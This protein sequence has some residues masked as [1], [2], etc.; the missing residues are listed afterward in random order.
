M[1][2]AIAPLGPEDALRIQRQRSQR[3]QLGLARDLSA[4]EAADLAASPGEAW[5]ARG[6]DGRLVACLGLR[7]TFPGRQAVAWAIL[8]EGIGAAHL[9]VTRFARARIAASPLARIEALVRERVAAERRWARLVEAA[10]ALGHV[11][12]GVG[13][14]EAGRFNQRAAQTGAIEEQRAG[15]AAETRIRDS[16]RAAIG[17]QL[18]AQG[19]NGFEQGSGSALDALADSQVSA[20]FDALQARDDAAR[21]ARARLVEGDI[22]RAQGNNALVSGLIGAGASLLQSRS[23]WAAAR[24]GTTPPAQTPTPRAGG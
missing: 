9:A 14:Y 13:G 8:A 6:R 16:A 2:V 3:I 4:A 10:M 24:R 15:A 18:A 5:A 21:R 20:A 11:V 12:A 17:A 1:S 22:A 19:A 23:D 7:E